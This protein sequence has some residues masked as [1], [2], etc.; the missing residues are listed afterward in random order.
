MC[1]NFLLP[2]RQDLLIGARG[3]LFS[4]FLLWRCRCL[5][6]KSRRIRFT[7]VDVTEDRADRISFLHLCGDLV[8]LAFARRRHAHDR[9]VR[10]DVNDFLIGGDFF[11]R[12]HFYID[13]SCFGNRFAQ[14]RHDDGNLR[15]KFILEE[16]FALLPQLFLRSDD[17]PPTNLDDMESACPSR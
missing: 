2:C 10:F 7:R 4:N 16:D 5:F 9:L 1:R 3:N 13:H 8:D 17:A 6:G 14:L 12:F 11:A 15:H